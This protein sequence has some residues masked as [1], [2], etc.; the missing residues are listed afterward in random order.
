MSAG[1]RDE[2]PGVVEAPV[3]DITVEREEEIVLTPV[4]ASDYRGEVADALPQVDDAEGAD[5]LSDPFGGMPESHDASDELPDVFDGPRYASYDETDDETEPSD[6]AASHLEPVPDLMAGFGEPEPFG[7]EPE[8]SEPETLFAG[9]GPG[10]TPVV[11]ESM[12]ELYLRQGH[13]ADALAIYRQ[14]AA[15]RPDDARLAS[16]VSGLAAEVDAPPA[17]APA[18]AAAQT[19]GRSVADLLRG[20]LSERL[21]A[22]PPAPE[23]FPESADVPEFRSRDEVLADAEDQGEPTRPADDHLTLGAVFGDED[24][25]A[26]PAVAS[27]ESRPSAHEQNGGLSFDEFFGAPPAVEPDATR[28]TPPA[29]TGD[30]DDLDQ[31]HAWL[32]SLKR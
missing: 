10:S 6:A 3:L 13:R 32:Q 7:D 21:P 19:G 30:P 29:P 25:G 20:I 14:L 22:A 1:G 31:F 9:G 27:P 4:P 23:P 12:A 11:T 16:V 28:T 15:R 18:Y 17:A 24:G 2:V 8:L 26:P 5:E